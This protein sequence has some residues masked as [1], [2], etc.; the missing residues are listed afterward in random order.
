MN[1]AASRLILAAAATAVT[2]AQFGFG[3]AP[4]NAQKPGQGAKSTSPKTRKAA[5]APQRTTILIDHGYTPS[6][7][8]LKAGRPVLL[9][10][11]R[12]ETGGCGDVVDFPSLGI[13]RTLKAGEKTVVAF[14]PKKAG[15]IAFTCGM[16]MY[17]G[18]LVVK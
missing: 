6:T 18:Q 8:S 14:T 16:N 9:T 1:H 5:S 12:K 4:A 3:S 15:T 10:L 2:A 11:V 17:K 13:K 7:V